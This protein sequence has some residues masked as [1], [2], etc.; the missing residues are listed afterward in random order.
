MEENEMNKPVK[1][2]DVK[3]PQSSK[4]NDVTQQKE[5]YMCE[6]VDVILKKPVI[7]ECKVEFNDIE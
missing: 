4:S 7:E 5:I 3:Y 2:Y 1:K 6:F